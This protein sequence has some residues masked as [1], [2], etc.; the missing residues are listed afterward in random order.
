MEVIKVSGMYTN[1]IKND[2][3]LCFFVAEETSFMQ[4]EIS[5]HVKCGLVVNV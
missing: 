4:A 5:D 2:T 3:S 1:I